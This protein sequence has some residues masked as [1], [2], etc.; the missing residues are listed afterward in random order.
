[1]KIFFKFNFN[2]SSIFDLFFIF[3][4]YFYFFPFFLLN[5]SIKKK[6]MDLGNKSRTVAS[7]NMN[8]VSSRS[9]ALFTIIFTQTTFDPE[10][11]RTTEKSSNLNC[12]VFH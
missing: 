3:Y 7:T 5:I 1:M 8:D 10:T 2:T 6:L 11:G 9:H 4:F 12:K